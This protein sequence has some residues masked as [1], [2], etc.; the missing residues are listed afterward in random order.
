MGSILTLEGNIILDA[1]NALRI[2]LHHLL[3]L[4]VLLIHGHNNNKKEEKELN[5]Q[6][7]KPTTT[8]IKEFDY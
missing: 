4:K 6:R 1:S 2:C 7:K 3:E 5:Q 8:I